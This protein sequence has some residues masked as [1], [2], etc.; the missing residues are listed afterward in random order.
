MCGK[1][2]YDNH[3]CIAMH[4][5]VADNVPV[6]PW[7]CKVIDFPL[8]GNTDAH[9]LAQSVNLFDS[10]ASICAL[11]VDGGDVGPV[12]KGEKLDHGL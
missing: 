3:M 1:G 11:R 12:V 7:G 9:A 4:A 2:K 8:V 6:L 5:Q 10:A